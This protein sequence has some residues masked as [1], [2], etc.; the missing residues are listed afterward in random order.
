[1]N[2]YTKHK[3]TQRHMKQTYGYRIVKGRQ[4]NY[5]FGINI[6]T[7]LYTKQITNKDQLYSTWNCTQYFVITYKGKQP[8]NIHTYYIIYKRAN[9]FALHLK[10]TKNCKPTILQNN[11]II[12]QLSKLKTSAQ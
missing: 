6:Y 8:E 11:Y 12:K 3:Q 4:T 1:M 2:L 9:Q 10:L 5:F 7:L